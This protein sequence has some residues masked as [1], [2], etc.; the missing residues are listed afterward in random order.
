MWGGATQEVDSAVG[1]TMR[2][3]PLLVWRKSS[4]HIRSYAKTFEFISLIEFTVLCYVDAH[5]RIAI[6]TSLLLKGVTEK[7]DI[8]IWCTKVYKN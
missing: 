8:K 4:K 5:Y 2:N 7:E 3:N 6:L 1:Y